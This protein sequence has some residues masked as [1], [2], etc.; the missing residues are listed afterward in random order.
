MIDNEKIK[1]ITSVKDWESAI[2][3]VAQILLDLG[4]ITT[5][6]IDAMIK[7]VKENG[8]YIVIGP[9][10]ALP[11][12]KREKGVLKTDISMLKLEKEVAFP[13]NKPVKLLICLAARNDDEHLDILSQI[14]DLLLDDDKVEKVLKSNDINELRGLINGL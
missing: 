12:A 4:S 2:K 5:E 1:I 7:N 14:G 6:Y 11:H 13:N 3:E 9:Y 10:I 8:S